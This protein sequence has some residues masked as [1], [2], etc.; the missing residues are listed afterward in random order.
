MNLPNQLTVLRLFFCAFFVAA[1]SSE[2]PYAL[3]SALVIF[4]AASLTDWLDGHLARK[5]NQVTDLGKLLDPLA[6]KVLISAALI[7]LLRFPLVPVP[8]WMVVTIIAREFLITGLRTLAA[9]KGYILAAEKLGK[10]KTLSQIVVILGSL[11]FVSLHELGWQDSRL[12]EALAASLPFLFWI[13]LLITVGSG[14]LYLFKNRGL[15]R[16]PS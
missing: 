12:E 13:A 10:H 9:S 4:L 14:A 16:D 7:G 6:D 15:F 5:W 3:T 8:L 11:T 2:S 1:L